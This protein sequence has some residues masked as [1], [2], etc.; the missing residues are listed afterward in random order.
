[1]YAKPY[2]ILTMSPH[3]PAPHL[4]AWQSIQAAMLYQFSSTDYLKNLHTIVTS[5]VDG[6]VDPLLELAKVQGRDW[7]IENDRWGKRD[8]SENWENNAWPHLKDLQ[9]SL[10]RDIARRTFGEYEK[11]AVNECLRAA[12]QSIGLSDLTL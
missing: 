12:E 2:S 6:V 4:T 5:L 11:T 1:M 7:V 3:P 9:L 8:T 10:A